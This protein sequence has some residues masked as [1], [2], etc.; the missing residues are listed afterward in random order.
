MPG[1]N[2]FVVQKG[3]REHAIVSRQRNEQCNG[4]SGQWPWAVGLK[5]VPHGNLAEKLVRLGLGHPAMP[6]VFVETG[7][8]VQ[9]SQICKPV[10]SVSFYA[11]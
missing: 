11:I 9:K 3:N 4:L 5:N 1:R 2:Y 10:S 8:N 7:T 6:S